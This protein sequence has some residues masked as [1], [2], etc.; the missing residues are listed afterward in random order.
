MDLLGSIL[1]SMDK[2]PALDEKQKK[3][4][5]SRWTILINYLWI[6]KKCLYSQ[7]EF[8]EDL[9]KKQAADKIKL[10]L[11]KENVWT[12]FYLFYIDFVSAMFF[13]KF[14]FCFQ[15]EKQI[16]DFIQD[17][18]LEK[19]AMEPMDKVSRSVVCVLKECCMWLNDI[20]VIIHLLFQTWNCRDC[21]SLCIFLW[22]R[23]YW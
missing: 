11:F 8:Q 19:I 16:N 22:W 3:I 14:Y 1:N 6:L 5:K 12:W 13:F 4:N 15:I 10:K 18:S 23:R 9:Q 21:R 7:T 2:P 20:L 17:D